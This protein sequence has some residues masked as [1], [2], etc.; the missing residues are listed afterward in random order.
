M[1]DEFIL[2]VEKLKALCIKE[3]YERKAGNSG[4]SSINQLEQIIKESDEILLKI[5]MGDIPPKSNRFF[6]SFAHAFKVWGWN[7]KNPTELYILLCQINS[8]YE[9]LE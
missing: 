6:N 7:M 3:L 5:S 1:Y 8:A 4:E 9:N 2:S